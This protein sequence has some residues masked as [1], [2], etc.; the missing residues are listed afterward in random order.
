MILRRVGLVM[1]LMTHFRDSFQTGIYTFF[2]NSRECV[3]VAPLMGKM[4]GKGNGKQCYPTI[5]IK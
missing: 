2:K 4:G 3:D 1:G 5:S